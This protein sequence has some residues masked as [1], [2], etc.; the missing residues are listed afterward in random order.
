MNRPKAERSHPGVCPS[1]GPVWDRPLRRGRTV[2]ALRR[3]RPPGRA[4]PAACNARR[5][6]TPGRPLFRIVENHK[7]HL[8]FIFT[9]K[10]VKNQYPILDYAIINYG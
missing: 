3:A 7:N 4:A 1:R 10:R 8:K 2:I 6:G 5:G 9:L